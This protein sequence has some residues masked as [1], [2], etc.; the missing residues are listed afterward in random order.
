MEITGP[1]VLGIDAGATKTTVAIAN[2]NTILGYGHSG[3]ANNHSTSPAQI[4]QHIQTAVH[5][6]LRASHLPPTTTFTYSVA[7]MAGI[8]S[9]VDEQLAKRILRRA[10]H[11]TK[12]MVVNDVHIVLRSG[13][14]NKYGLALICGTGAQGFG[15]NVKGETARVGGLE[16]LISDEGSGYEMGN[17]ALRAALRSADGRIKHTILE[18]LVLKHFKIKAIRDIEPLIYH[19]AY[20]PKAEIGQLSVLV[21]QAAKKNDWRA[22]EIINETTQ[23]I[24]L[25]IHTLI[26]RLHM[27]KDSFDIVLVGG[28][29]KLQACNFQQ[30]LYAGIKRIAPTATIIIPKQPPVLGAVRL[31]WEKMNV[32]T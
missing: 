1:F 13:S 4:I 9:M 15:I 21:E 22:K 19:Q 24:L 8:D 5:K 17:K 28:M 26:Q 30:H 16:Y 6:A 27:K 2:Q 3:P 7:G 12:F 31:A 18:E 14:K 32:Q 29:F 23:E 10:L 11:T 20:V 25:Y